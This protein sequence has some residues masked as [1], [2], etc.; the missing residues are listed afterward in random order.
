MINETL[1]EFFILH[2]LY[3]HSYIYSGWNRWTY[4]FLFVYR[5]VICAHLAFHQYLIIFFGSFEKRQGQVAFVLWLA[6]T[7]IFNCQKNYETIL[8]HIYASTFLSART[9]LPFLYS[10][11]C[12][13]S[14]RKLWEF[15]SNLYSFG[16][17]VESCCKSC[18]TIVDMLI[19]IR[20]FRINLINSSCFYCFSIGSIKLWFRN[21]AFWFNCPKARWSFV[22]IQSRHF[23]ST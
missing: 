7:V 9:S 8:W 3:P 5:W 21:F 6:L 12:F 16:V 18:L 4:S 20:L 10:L 1:V 13:W 17:S 11:I 15:G 23:Y 2:V 22:W 14:F 19:G